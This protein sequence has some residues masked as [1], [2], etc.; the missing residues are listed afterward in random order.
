MRLTFCFCSSE[1]Y[2]G[3]FVNDTVL[4]EHRGGYSQTLNTYQVMLLLFCLSPPTRFW[5]PGILQFSVATII[6]S[7]PQSPKVGLGKRSPRH[8]TDIFLKLNE[9]LVDEW[10]QMSQFTWFA[11]EPFY[12]ALCFSEHEPYMLM[13][14]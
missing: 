9:S 14:P 7:F 1:H 6:S 11:A 12:R 3:P 2:R 8:R 4:S 13:S 5:A 10:A